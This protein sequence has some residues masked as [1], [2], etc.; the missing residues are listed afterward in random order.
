VATGHV[1]STILLWDLAAPASVRPSAPFDADQLLASWNVLADADAGRAFAALARLTGVPDQAVGLLRE[2]L[3]PVQAP[4]AEE[5]ARLVADLDNAQFARRESATKQLTE[6][7]ELADAALRKVLS[8]AP[9]LEVRRRI[10]ALLAQPPIARSAEARRGL[11][12]V[13]LLEH[14]GNPEARQMLAKLAT[15]TP[16][17]RVTQEAKASL[18]RLAKRVTETP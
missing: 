18:E 14:I 4:P 13:R 10:E 5:L 15:G 3:R 12:T 8:K 17:A 2:R 9:P 6:L 11:R 7:G 1:D 16:D